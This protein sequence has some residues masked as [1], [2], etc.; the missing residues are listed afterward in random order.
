MIPEKRQNP[1]GGPLQIRRSGTLCLTDLGESEGEVSGTGCLTYGWRADSA[2]LWGMADASEC[3]TRCRWF[4]LT[5]G[6]LVLGLLAVE[7][8]LLL[9]EHFQW[10]AFNR[11]K[12]WTVLIGM[13]D[14]VVAMLLMFLWFLAALIF[15]WR[16]Q[17]SIRSLLLLTVVVA[18]PC[19]WLAV[20]MEAG[21][22]TAGGGGMD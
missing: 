1:P 15:R 11:H 20:E 22:E 3:K 4:R 8:F 5:P 19:S 9:S 2:I 7:G 6:C 21:E 17:F 18:I 12:G 13:A 14:V 16:F 10:F